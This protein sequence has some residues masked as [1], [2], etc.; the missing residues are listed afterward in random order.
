MNIYTLTYNRHITVKG[1]SLFVI[2]ATTLLNSNI[3]GPSH[4]FAVTS[5]ASLPSTID[6]LTPFWAWMQKTMSS[7]YQSS[8]PPPNYLV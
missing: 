3:V 7:P 1:L 2:T 4:S 8:S 5:L 6:V